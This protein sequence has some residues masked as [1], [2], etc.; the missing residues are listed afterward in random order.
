MIRNDMRSH[1]SSVCSDMTTRV[2]ARKQHLVKL[3][4]KSPLER[5]SQFNA[6]LI[7]K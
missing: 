7:Y 6:S 5:Q 1:I 3:I 4:G 2:K